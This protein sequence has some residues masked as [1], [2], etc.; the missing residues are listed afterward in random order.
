M[1]TYTY[2]FQFIYLLHAL[3]KHYYPTCP[4]PGTQ[5]CISEYTQTHTH[6]HAN[7]NRPTSYTTSNGCQK[8]W[9]KKK[10]D[11]ETNRRDQ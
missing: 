1:Y 8:H 3:E 9:K 2:I 7:M 10:K 6:I 11:E 5:Q 4:T